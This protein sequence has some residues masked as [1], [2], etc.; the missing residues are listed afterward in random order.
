MEGG[1][2]GEGGGVEERCG[3]EVW[4]EGRRCGGEEVWRRGGVEERRCGGRGGVCE[5][6]CV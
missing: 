6:R 2:V 5:G 1:G 4:G 3:E